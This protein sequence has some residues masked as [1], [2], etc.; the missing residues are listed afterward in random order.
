MR[1]LSDLVR[2]IESVGVPWSN[3]AFTPADRPAPPYIELEAC[4]SVSSYADNA[5]FMQ[6]MAYDVGLY[7]A[8]RDYTLEWRLEHAL[9]ASGFTYE[10][11]VTPIDSERVIETAYQLSAYEDAAVKEENGD[12]SNGKA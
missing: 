4:Y 7:C 9:A 3:G 6:W 1:M 8:A 5:C 10:K 2:A 12:N 11:T